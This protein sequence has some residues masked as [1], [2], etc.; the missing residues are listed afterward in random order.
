MKSNITMLMHLNEFKRR[1][2]RNVSKK[3][4]MHYGDVDEMIEY[5]IHD[6]DK[7]MKELGEGYV[8]KKSLK[9][10]N[11]IYSYGNSILSAKAGIVRNSKFNKLIK[12][13]SLVVYVDLNEDNFIKALK[14][15]GRNPDKEYHLKSYHKEKEIYFKE[16]DI[17]V[18]TKNTNSKDISDQIVAE[19][20]KYY[21]RNNK[22]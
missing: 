15:E 18:K 17:I 4:K 14:R 21:K 8:E 3:L 11:G 6:I 5:D 20:L 19:I 9:V 1:V 13:S 12:E 2:L 10:L 16:A 22:I 7:A